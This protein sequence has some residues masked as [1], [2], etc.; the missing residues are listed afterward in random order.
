MVEMME[1]MEMMEMSKNS[2]DCHLVKDVRWILDEKG[3]WMVFTSLKAV[4][5]YYGLLWKVLS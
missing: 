5:K 4:P 1:M 3:V 2:E